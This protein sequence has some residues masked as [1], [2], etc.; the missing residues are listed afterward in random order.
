MTRLGCPSETPVSTVIQ[1]R[2][3]SFY[4]QLVW[5]PTGIGANLSGQ[6][7]HAQPGEDTAYRVT[8]GNV[9]VDGSPVTFDY[10][11]IVIDPAAPAPGP[12]TWDGSDSSN[13]NSCQNWS[14]NRTPLPMDSVTIPAGGR[15][16]VVQ[17]GQAHVGNLTVADGANLT[18]SGGALTLYGNWTEQGSGRTSSSGGTVHLRGN[19]GQTLQLSNQSTLPNVTVGGGH[20]TPQ[21]TINGRATIRGDLTI[22]PGASLQAG[23][24][25]VAGDWND[26]NLGS[27]FLSG[28]GTVV[29]EGGDQQVDKVTNQ[30]VLA[31]DFNARSDSFCSNLPLGWSKAQETAP[32]FVWCGT[33]SGISPGMAMLFPQTL[34]GWLFSP[35][36]SLSPGVAYQLA[37]DYGVMDGDGSFIAYVA[38]GAT[39]AAML[40]TSPIHGP[41]DGSTTLQSAS[42]SFT[43][44][45]PGTY[46]I[47]WRAQQSNGMNGASIDNVAVSG[48]GLL[49]FNHVRVAAGTTTFRQGM[50][51][52]GNLTVDASAVAAFEADSITVDG[53]VTN[54]GILAQQRTVDNGLAR[55]LHIQ[56]RAGNATKYTGVDITPSGPGLGPT[57]VEIGGNQGACN[58]GDELVRRCF[59]IAPQ[60]AQP[61]T[62]RFWYLN[63]ERGG[64]AVA[65]VNAFHWN[66]ATWDGLTLGSPG[67]GTEGPYEWV[68][69]VDV[70]SYSPF[71][72]GTGPITGA[73]VTEMDLAG[74]NLPIPSGGASPSL[75]NH[76]DFGGVRVDEGTIVRTFT[77]LN[78]RNIP[79]LLSGTPPVALSGSGAAHFQVIS[80]PTTPV[81]GGG[82]VTFQ[83]E[84]TP[85]VE[86]V[87][88]AVVT[89]PNND[90]DENPYTFTIQGRG[91]SDEL[92]F[93]PAITNGNA[94]PVP[95]PTPF[96]PGSVTATPTAT[97][98]SMPPTAT[99]TS[100][101]P[102]A[103]P[104]AVPP[105]ATATPTQEP[106]VL[107]S[108]L[109]QAHRVNVETGS[110][111]NATYD[112]TLDVNSVNAAN[113]RVF[114]M[115]SGLRAG[116]YT[117]NGATAQMQP[118]QPFLPGEEVQI[119]LGQ[120]IRGG[121]GAAPEASTVW[122]F[123]AATAGGSGQLTSQGTIGEAHVWWAIAIGDLNQDGSQDIVEAA[124]GAQS[125]VLLNDGQGGFTTS[126]PFGASLERFAAVALG[127]MDNDG[128]LDIVAVGGAAS[129]EDLTDSVFLNNGDGT[130]APAIPLERA[131]QSQAVALG[132]LNGDGLLDIVTGRALRTNRVYLNQ[133]GG[134]FTGADLADVD[135]FTL[136]LALGDVD[137]DGD[138]DVMVLNDIRGEQPHRV[139]LNNGEGLFPSSRELPGLE[140]SNLAHGDLDGDGDLDLVMDAVPF[141]NDGTGNFT[142]G[143]P[144]ADVATTY[145]VAL[146]DMN[147][148][149]HL[150]WIRLSYTLEPLERVGY[151]YLNDGS[152]GFGSP[153]AFTGSTYFQHMA[154]GDLNGD[155]ALDLV[156]GTSNLYQTGEIFLNG[157]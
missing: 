110:G 107:L 142:L 59:D 79:L 47:G 86:G 34:D 77:I 105:T 94:F 44:S 100:V 153:L 123:R 2:G 89:I 7:S 27:G 140:S 60:Q 67:R 114:G 128:D 75:G 138:L 54:N 127:D 9:T 99:P 96:D 113:F 42:A 95:T 149:S 23:T 41:V 45:S 63:S 18:I 26:R 52:A 119:T 104:T 14:N 64:Q 65:G 115:Q 61:A 81:S 91:H 103:T 117:V 51:A 40:A 76:T 143:T 145:D 80:Q 148:D 150:D 66:G 102:T 6:G 124:Y 112:Q 68:E 13:W 50:T 72:L 90:G 157:E 129:G 141:L 24:L 144:L 137:G 4:K 125:R 20:A 136:D 15:A 155:G 87:H 1:Y 36:L 93:L 5:V 116:A 10:N 92:L 57:W 39:P 111:V 29:F 156:T 122:S 19:G 135:E 3:D 97:S 71:G 37:Y 132:D 126:H 11:V 120:G 17:D 25:H 133:G 121:N 131:E 33:G 53:T 58:V 12:M 73:P 35:P 62:V 38:N 83:I 56:N 146:A 48:Q 98:T 134:S 85:T 147:G 32:G 106:L 109:P 152:G 28:N 70:S 22:E 74:N 49:N 78:R 118:G 88:Q 30:T 108:T 46:Y 8:I 139:Y 82:S 16:P 84:F 130:F 151:I 101:P 43:V 154:V 69:A 55:F 31:E 21:V